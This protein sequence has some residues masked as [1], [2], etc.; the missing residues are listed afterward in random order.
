MVTQHYRWDF[1]GLSTDT[2][3]TPET[4]EKVVDGSTFYCSDNSKLYVWCK[5]QWYEKEVSGGGGTTYTAGDGI[6]IDDGEIAVDLVQTTGNST[7]KVMS[8]N[9]TTSMVYAD[10]SSLNKIKIGNNSVNGGSYNITI[11][12]SSLTNNK[13]S[14]CIAFG[15][16]ATLNNNLNYSTAIGYYAKCTR[17]GEMN[18]GTTSAHGYNGTNYRVLG[19]VHDPVDAQDAATKHYVDGLIGNIETALNTINNGTGE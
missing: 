14:Y 4:S 5:N 17:S 13:N 10:P 19:G 18:I 16:R 2:K 3:P 8:Q 6:V 12:A 15:E 11:G 9:A 1:I 7:K